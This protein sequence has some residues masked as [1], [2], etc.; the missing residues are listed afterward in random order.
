MSDE[1]FAALIGSLGLG[2]L[3]AYMV[4]SKRTNPKNVPQ[5]LNYKNV[6]FRF[7]RTGKVVPKSWTYPQ[8]PEF[9]GAQVWT[10][11]SFGVGKGGDIGCVMFRNG[12]HPDWNDGFDYSPSKYPN[13][14]V[15]KVDGFS[16][17][18]GPLKWRAVLPEDIKR[19]WI[20]DHRQAK[21]QLEKWFFE[22]KTE[23]SIIDSNSG[24]DWCNV[25]EWEP[26]HPSK[27][28]AKVW[29]PIAEEFDPQFE[30]TVSEGLV[31]S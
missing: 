24:P 6:A 28:L 30:R 7:S 17:E 13:I 9:E 4:R 25:D 1:R 19:A 8:T 12:D 2:G 10:Y 14:Q 26:Y 23:L 11:G 29:I 5:D 18:K 27:L 3:I 16:G 20:L 21:S 22:H 31:N 15:F